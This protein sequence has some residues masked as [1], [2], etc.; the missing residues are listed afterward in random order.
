[1]QLHMEG[2]GLPAKLE[3]KKEPKAMRV[4]C[5]EESIGMS[6]LEGFNLGRKQL[7]VL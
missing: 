3:I 6:V 2:P 5:R 4:R 7:R 1:M